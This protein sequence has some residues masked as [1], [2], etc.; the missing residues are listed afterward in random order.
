MMAL[1]LK[2]PDLGTAVILGMAT[3]IM[4]FVAGAKI[5]YI[6]IAFW[7]RRR[8]CIRRSSRTPWRCAA[9]S[10]FSI[11]G[12]TAYG[13]RLSGHRVADSRSAR[14]ACSGLGSATASRSSSLARGAHRLRDGHRRRGARAVRDLRGSRRCSPFSFGAARAR[15]CGRA[16]RSAAT[17]AS[18]SPRCSRCRRWSTSASC[19][20]R[21]RPRG[22]R[23]RSSASAAH[24]R[25]RPLRHGILLN[26]SRAAPEPAGARSKGA[27]LPPHSLAGEEGQ[28]ASSRRRQCASKSHEDIDRRRRNGGHSVPGFAVAEE[29]SA[30][31]TRFIS[32]ARKRESR[33]RAGTAK[34]VLFARPHRY[35]RYPRERDSK[36]LYRDCWSRTARDEPIA[37]HLETREARCR[38]RRRWLRLGPM[39]LAAALGGKPTA[40]LEQNVGSGITTNG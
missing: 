15:R 19:S 16:M 1:L 17:S 7:R 20:A 18:A 28:S 31:A 37:R 33:A 36:E 22:C 38:R 8:S 14:A 12:S 23:C 21:C 10:R 11:R 9:C 34:A 3:L 2:Q 27:W 4:L 40:I 30:R 24:A 26:I 32:W 39:V 6:F 25:G 29:W 5:S 13:R 35:R